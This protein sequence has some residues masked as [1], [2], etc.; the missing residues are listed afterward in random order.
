[1]SGIKKLASFDIVKRRNNDQPTPLH[2]VA[3]DLEV[4]VDKSGSM[5]SMGNV[6]AEQIHELI[7]DQRKLALDENRKITMSVTV[8][9]STANT[10]ID[11]IDLSDPDTQLPTFQEVANMLNPGGLTRFYDT[12]LERVASQKARAKNIVKALP[13]SIRSLN[14][15]VNRILY[16]LTDGEDNKS[17]MGM[18]HLRTALNTNKALGD[19][20][21]V[22]LAANIGDAEIVGQ[23]MGFDADTSL[24][25]G[26]T[27]QFAS[28]GMNHANSL[29]R[30]VSG[31]AAPPPFTHSM[32]QSSCAP[33]A[34]SAAALAAGLMDDYSDDEDNFIANVAPP[35]PRIPRVN[36][37]SIPRSGGMT[38]HSYNLRR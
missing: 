9:D 8:F 33:P 27:P 36:L 21:A 19:F 38:S 37:R 1:M 10:V 7:K 24:T 23:Q 30:A 5:S 17:S 18:Q 22:F 12:I 15:R 25:I 31:G 34:P 4:V 28:V 26:N 6:P 14:P 32:R 16:V 20:T 11:N 3:T 35:L 13:Y 2:A 29:L